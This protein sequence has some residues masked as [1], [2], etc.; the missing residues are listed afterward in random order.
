MMLWDSTGQTWAWQKES[1]QVLNQASTES[2]HWR[3]SFHL[4]AYR[5]HRRLPVN[6]TTGN[7]TNPVL[8]TNFHIWHLMTRSG[9]ET[10]RPKSP[11]WTFPVLFAFGLLN[12]PLDFNETL[13]QPVDTRLPL[14]VSSGRRHLSSRTRRDTD[15]S[16]PA[17]Q[18]EN[19]RSITPTTSS[20]IPLL[21]QVFPPIQIMIKNYTFWTIQLMIKNYTFWYVF[22]K[23][24]NIMF[25]LNNL[26]CILNL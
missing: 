15:P 20:K 13:V 22:Y 18:G 1:R 14:D 6:G 16:R 19:Y 21:W 26:L 4:V 5:S 17:S 24:G 7:R 2:E 10:R 25:G 23:L 8:C 12:R 3:R 11:N 9:H